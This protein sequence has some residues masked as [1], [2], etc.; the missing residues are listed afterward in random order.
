MAA[1]TRRTGKKVIRAKPHGERARFTSGTTAPARLPAD[2][3]VELTELAERMGLDDPPTMSREQIV[4]LL[5]SSAVADS[6]SSEA[7][8]ELHLAAWRAVESYAAHLIRRGETLEEVGDPDALARTIERVLPRPNRYA[9]RI[10][11]VYT[12]GQLRYALPGAGKSPISEQAV[13]NRIDSGRLIAFKTADDRWAAPA[14]QFRVRPGGLEVRE[15]VIALWRRLPMGGPIAT[16]DLVAWLT[17]RRRDLE[18]TTPLQ[19]LEKHGLDD[20]LE[21]AAGQLRRR[22]A[23]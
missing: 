13:R 9:A 10:G 4:E 11:P 8:R 15:P 2:E 18:D 16:V 7:L 17:G 19:W 6:A 23:A 5:V 3:P 1:P 20:R 14:F 21:R 12:V 22:A